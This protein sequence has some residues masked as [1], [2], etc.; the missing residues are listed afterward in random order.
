MKGHK[1]MKR[2]EKYKS[3]FLELKQI[4]ITFSLQLQNLEE[5][6]VFGV[7]PDIDINC[8]SI[9]NKDECLIAKEEEEETKKEEKSLMTPP[10]SIAKKESL[11]KHCNT[12][13]SSFQLYNAHSS[14]QKS[15]IQHFF[16]LL[17]SLGNKQHKV[18][19]NIFEKCLMIFFKNVIKRLYFCS[20]FFSFNKEN[21]LIFV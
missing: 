1:R 8:S 12:L 14:S 5:K 4:L 16:M 2:K 9:E 10:T 19:K 18:N 15:Q 13:K 6:S 17:P 11:K 21:Y 3:L 20:I 7:E